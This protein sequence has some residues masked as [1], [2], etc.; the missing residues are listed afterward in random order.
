MINH[1]RTLLINKPKS[2]AHHS[3]LGYEYVPSDFSPVELTPTLATVR[4]ILFGSSPDNYFLNFRA[5]E[6][7]SYI[8]QTEL[9]QYVYDLDSRVTYWPRTSKPFFESASKRISITQTLGAPQRLTVAG[10]LSAAPAIGRAFNTYTVNLRET[11]TSSTSAL[12]VDVKHAGEEQIKSTQ[13]SAQI[14]SPAT[15]PI[16][17]L[18]QTR[19][20]L[21]VNLTSTQT[22]YSR[23]L[24]EENGILIVESYLPDLGGYLLAEETSISVGTS[25]GLP[26][27]MA[28][29]G[30][31][32]A[33]VAQWLVET[34]ANPDPVITTAINPLENLGEPALL[35]IFGVASVE[36]Y[37][38][39]KNL[40]LDHP[41]PAYRLSG[42]VLALIYRTEQLRSGHAN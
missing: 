35:D 30:D 38:T 39:F 42:M 25:G 29:T 10:N 12:Y 20:N 6:L 22:A 27:R 26:M 3:D 32:S 8:H 18:A 9:A 1:A 15:P 16:I 21:R 5:A 31:N 11:T 4:K 7:L 41:L 13:V 19:L 2:R 24:T 23:I 17:P 28:N 14:L 40:W 34:K 33:I 36:P 37:I